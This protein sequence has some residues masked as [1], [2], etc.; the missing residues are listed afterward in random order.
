MSAQWKRIKH[1]VGDAL[2][3]PSDA[4]AD[5]VEAACAGDAAIESAVA[6]LLAQSG[7]PEFLQTLA[8]LSDELDAGSVWIGRQLGSYQIISEIFS[9]GMGRVFKARRIDGAYESTVAV[10]IL[11]ANIDSAEGR[12][13]FNMERQILAN[14]QHPRI[15][16]LLDGSTIDG[17]PY[18]VMEYVDGIP[19]DQYCG[20]QQLDLPGRLNIFSSICDAVEFAHQQLI[21]HRDLKP[22]NILVTQDGN[23]K[24]LD[25][26]IAKL[27]GADNLDGMS[28]LT[29]I[30]EFGPYT[31]AYAAPEQLLGQPITTATDV[32]ALGCILYRLLT[33]RL[34]FDMDTVR[35]P[36]WMQAVCEQAPE[37]PSLALQRTPNADDAVLRAGLPPVQKLAGLLRGDLDLIVLKALEKDVSQRYRTVAQLHADIR[38]YLTGRI[39]SAQRPSLYGSTAKFI[40]RNRLPVGIAALAAVALVVGVTGIVWQA[41]VAQTM[42][43]KAENRLSDVQA[44]SEK[45]I[46][47]YND[48]IKMLPG[49]LPVSQLLMSDVSN[50]LDRLSNES[51]LSPKMLMDLALSYQRLATAQGGFRLANL[52]KNDASIVS[53]GKAHAIMTRLVEQVAQ[54]P[55]LLPA[56]EK[57]DKKLSRWKLLVYASD[58]ERDLMAECTRLAQFDQA[59]VHLQ[60]AAALIDQ[61]AALQPSPYQQATILTDQAQF[62]AHHDGNYKD[63]I[64]LVRRAQ[65][66][67][68]AVLKKNGA[69]FDARALLANQY[70]GEGLYLQDGMNDGKAA[71]ASFLRGIGQD[72]LLHAAQPH[73]TE[74]TQTLASD[75][76][77]AGSIEFV[78][79]NIQNARLLLEEARATISPLLV[80]DTD[81]IHAVY[82][83]GI[84]LNSLANFY[85]RAKHHGDAVLTLNQMRDISATLLKADAKSY[86]NIYYSSLVH[87][88][89]AKILVL[90][91]KI[92]ASDAEMK[93]CLDLLLPIARLDNGMYRR[94]SGLQ[95]GYAEMLLDDGYWD[96]AIDIL[97]DMARLSISLDNRKDGDRTV[98]FATRLDIGLGRA[99]KGKAEAARAQQQL[100]WRERS[101]DHFENAKKAVAPLVQAG[102]ASA[103]DQ[104]WFD[105]AVAESD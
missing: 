69:D 47:D 26:G 49:A 62:Y 57:D 41:Q 70:T 3:L 15:A 61:A 9:G 51:D 58:L 60:R 85:I 7:K 50:Y 104:A 67:T 79:N 75:L 2:D 1:I 96:E 30:G 6:A 40:K 88:T 38:R 80:S 48:K 44:L 84:I 19:I 71:L 68:A 39:V 64:K 93:R 27:L 5:F 72:R 10:K 4:R 94:M 59:R 32:Y 66:M 56:T 105:K 22:E 90:D 28:N 63:A 77:R 16:N 54:H 97:N 18:F 8:T 23:P 14:L 20:A 45:M 91:K 29:R 99:Y 103:Q 55:G 33:G 65:E 53:R 82:I 95:F 11:R 46:F 12:I 37:R 43:V 89:H 83:G 86:D 73:N 17:L 78:N 74:V 24:L 13:R 87:A 34:P 92:P 36:G 102:K 35:G 52:G 31:L 25:F 42:R 76:Y 98:R 21:V 100:A 81:N 101:R